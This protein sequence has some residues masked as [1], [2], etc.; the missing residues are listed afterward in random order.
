MARANIDFA[1]QKLKEYEETHIIEDE[2]IQ[3]HIL[4]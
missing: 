3:E 1:Q 4:A 2:H